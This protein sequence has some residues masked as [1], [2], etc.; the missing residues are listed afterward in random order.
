MPF[1]ALHCS[2]PVFFYCPPSFDLITHTAKILNLTTSFQKTKQRIV[3]ARQPPCDNVCCCEMSDQ[4]ETEAVPSRSAQEVSNNTASL[5]ANQ[6][7]PQTDVD[8]QDLPGLRHLGTTKL[9]ARLGGRFTETMND[10]LDIF[11]ELQISKLYYQTFWSD[12]IYRYRQSTRHLPLLKRGTE[13]SI[14]NMS[15]DILR[16]YGKRIWG[17]ES[18][19]RG[20]LSAG[21]EMLVYDKDGPN[22][23]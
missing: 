3:S 15:D 21:E 7:A 22:D 2:P 16:G 9:R 14:K 10:Y 23:R 5:T 8:P 19:W 11:Q 6:L 4:S 12:V 1:Q 13:V 20:N 18:A 17:L